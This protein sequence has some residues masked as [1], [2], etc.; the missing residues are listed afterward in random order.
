MM[1]HEMWT[2]LGSSKYDYNFVFATPSTVAMYDLMPEEE[3]INLKVSSPH[4]QQRS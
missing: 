4:R 2:K 1:A 3:R